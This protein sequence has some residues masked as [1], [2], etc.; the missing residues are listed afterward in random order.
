VNVDVKRLV[1]VNSTISPYP[2]QLNVA[3]SIFTDDDEDDTTIIASNCS[4]MQSAANSTG[5][6]STLIAPKHQHYAIM[7]IEMS[8]AIADMGATSIF[9]MEGTLMEN[10]QPTAH[11]ITIN[12]P[13]GKK[14]M[15]THTCNITIPGLST[16][17]KGHIVPEIKMASLFGIRVL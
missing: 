1:M 12:L 9:V 6:I 16:V 4:R 15:S 7:L 11:P 14:V 17:L 8:H 5:T 3:E 10:V 13:D 2:T